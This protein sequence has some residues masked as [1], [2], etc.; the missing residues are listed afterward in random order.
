MAV[1]A[2][3]ESVLSLEPSTWGVPPTTA[4]RRRD[5]PWA[6]V[7]LA[8]AG[9][10]VAAIVAITV[11]VGS[12]AL[13]GDPA[14]AR[15]NGDP[16]ADHGSLVRSFNSVV[17]RYQSADRT[18]MSQAGRIVVGSAASAEALIRPSVQ[19]ADTVDQVDHDLVHLS[20][21]PSMR[22]DVTALEA[23]LATVSGDL[24]SI[25]GQR[26]TSMRQWLAN[27]VG[28]ASQSSADSDRLARHLGA[29]AQV[30]S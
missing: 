14:Q 9:V 19:F 20:W 10:L 13:S 3:A 2:Q 27:V 17:E 12:S 28:D 7:G 23:D 26:V 18:W 4:P 16:S 29:T 25:G 1:T 24:R 6:A 11:T 5:G 21:P 30:G 22:G 15:I 8:G